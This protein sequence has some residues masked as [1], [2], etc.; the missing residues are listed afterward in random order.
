MASVGARTFL[1]GDINGAGNSAM[2]VVYIKRLIFG[3][4]IRFACS[5][6]YYVAK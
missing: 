1:S 2:G 3:L 5:N 4:L 6:S